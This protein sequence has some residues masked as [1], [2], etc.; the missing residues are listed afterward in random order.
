[1][2]TK[3]KVKKSGGKAAIIKA[4]REFVLTN[5][6][7][8]SSVFQ[9]CHSAGMAEEEFYDHFSSISRIE[10][11][12]WLS[13][14]ENSIAAVQE[15][16][17]ISSFSG[18]DKMLLFFFSL[19]QQLK[20]DRSFVCWSAKNWAKP[21]RHSSARKEVSERV[22]VWFE[23]ILSA[24]RSN[25]EVKER[26]KISSHYA[27]GLM[28]SFW[29]IL[30]FWMKDESSGFEDTDALIEKTIGL[31]FDLL[32]ESPLEKAID[33]GRFLLGRLRPV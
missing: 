23:E 33:L 20:K 17:D 25:G 24:S 31:A 27:D 29:F 12:I 16:P 22:K 5:E 4:Y 7:N 10:A 1:M 26:S 8:P 11:E 32:S 13:H 9:L 21:G 30:D 19:V 2:E 14:L 3:T 6:K 15:N 28:L 18:K